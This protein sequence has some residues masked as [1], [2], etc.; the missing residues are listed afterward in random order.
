M[1]ARTNGAP[2][3]DALRGAY[4]VH[5]PAKPAN[6]IVIAT[7]AEV[8]PTIEA[9]NSLAGDGI[10]A[11]VVSMPCVELFL[12]QDEAYRSRVLQTGLP[13]AA[14]EMGRPEPWC[15]F[16]G[17]IDRVHGQS[18]FGASAPAKAL[19]EHFGWTPAAIAKALRAG[20]GSLAAR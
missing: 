14:V 5:E 12:R 20:F 10:H 16:T 19:T 15:R 6:A 3:A 17:S 4:V 1:L 8:A 13:V 11:R 7:G 2:K 18:T 9:V